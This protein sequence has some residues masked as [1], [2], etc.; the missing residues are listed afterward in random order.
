MALEIKS[1]PVLKGKEAQAFLDNLDTQRNEVK[2]S[3][4][5]K[6]KIKSFASAILAKAKI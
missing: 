1:T 5:E 3:D 2:V 4:Q 6:Q